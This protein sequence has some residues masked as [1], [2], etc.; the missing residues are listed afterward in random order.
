MKHNIL[1]DSHIDSTS[2]GSL[3]DTDVGRAIVESIMFNRGYN[4]GWN[5]GHYEFT[6]V[7]N[8]RNYALPSDFLSLTSSVFYS[9]LNDNNIPYGKRELRWRPINWINASLTNAVTD[10]S[11]ILHWDVGTTTCYGI[12]PVTN[13][14]CLV[15]VPTGG[16]WYIEYDYLRDPGTPTFKSDGTTW[17][18]YTP[19][20]SDE[21]PATYTNE[22]FDVDKGYNL[23]LNRALYLI[24]NRGYGGSEEMLSMAQNFLKMWAEEL[25]RQRGQANRL[26]GAREIRKRI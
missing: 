4:L 23:I 26:V 16:P 2:S 21:L 17:T 10:T 13:N 1:R 25:N 22:W 24:C 11:N 12:D 19:G 9:S 5:N 7:E 6:T 8:V 3:A 15:P 14:M 18:F 20:T